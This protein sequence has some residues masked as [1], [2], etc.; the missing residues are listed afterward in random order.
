[1]PIDA[2]S[3]AR[4]DRDRFFAWCESRGL[5]R[6]Q[7]ISEAFRVSSQTIRNWHRKE[8]S[9]PLPAWVPLACLA[10]EALASGKAVPAKGAPMTVARLAAWQSRHGF[11]TYD[12]TARVFSVTR[13]AVHN[14]YKRQRFPKWLALACLG[15]D[16][17][18]RSPHGKESVTGRLTANPASS[19]IEMAVPE[20]RRDDQ[21]VCQ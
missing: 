21:G 11:M 16:L 18:G 9:D 3:D 2:R 17:S 7:D 13:Q 1:M 20:G 8:S 19:N 4:M 12:D 14:W 5:T 6:N 10:V 15:Y